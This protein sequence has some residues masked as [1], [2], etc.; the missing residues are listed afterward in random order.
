M[1]KKVI[2]GTTVALLLAACSSKE[3]GNNNHQKSIEKG[4]DA[5]AEN[6]F[7]KAE[8]LFELSVEDNPNDQTTKAYLKQVL[9]I[10]Q[11][12][13]DVGN[14]KVEE[15]IEVLKKAEKYEKGS[16]VISTKAEEQIKSLTV[17]KKTEETYRQ[18][19]DEAEA[20]AKK[21]NYKDSNDK[22]TTLLNEDLD[23]YSDI[24]QVA[25]A[26]KKI[27]SA[28]IEKK[29]KAEQKLAG[30]DEHSTVTQPT[31]KAYDPYEWAPGVKEA[32][33][34]DLVK[35][36]YADSVDTIRYEK[37]QV[38]NNQGFYTV[39]AQMDGVEMYVVT[40]N[41]KTGDYHG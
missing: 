13:E 9:L 27:N 10:R 41:V 4:L 25:E 6:D 37:S 11:A 40:V 3:T 34:A 16:K 31:E 20:L 14:D 18:L 29:A 33:E 5:V 32:F 21:A 19:F 15:R 26:L 17:S 28:E 35:Q 2:I 7:A 39:Y 36:Q 38:Y 30:K 1:I 22:L 8:A 23:N 12:N 24:Q